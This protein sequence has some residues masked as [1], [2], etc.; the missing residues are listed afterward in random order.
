MTETIRNLG[1]RGEL[2]RNKAALACACLEACESYTYKSSA[3]SVPWPDEARQIA[4]YRQLIAPRY[5]ELEPFK[6]YQEIGDLMKTNK[7][8]AFY[9]LRSIKLIENN[10]LQLNVF[11]ARSTTI[12]HREH[13]I[14]TFAQVTGDFG[15]ILNLWTGISFVTVIQMVE[16]LYVLLG[17]KKA[18]RR[19]PRSSAEG[20]ELGSN[21]AVVAAES[22]H[23]VHRA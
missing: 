1:C 21:K 13:M 18:S 15:G 20:A 9:R 17:R 11:L 19:V 3:S 6:V 23:H 10:F 4:L 14:T 7:T 8:E 5:P 16:L 22:S 12:V 2:R